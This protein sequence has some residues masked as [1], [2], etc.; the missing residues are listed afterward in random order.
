MRRP[1]QTV[2]NTT[3]LRKNCVARSDTLLASPVVK[4]FDVVPCPSISGR[5]T[6]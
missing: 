4:N 6:R 5:R 3:R 1:N 2:S